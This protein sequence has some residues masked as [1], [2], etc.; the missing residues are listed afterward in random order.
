MKGNAGL[1]VALLIVLVSAV[2]ILI[3][4]RFSGFFALTTGENASLALWDITDS[5]GGNLYVY[6]D[7]SPL[8]SRENS[9]TLARFYANYTN[10]TSGQSI[11]GT[12]VVCNISFNV[13]GAFT[14]PANMWFNASSRLYVYNR[15]FA[16]RG[17]YPWNA[18]CYGSS[19]NYDTLTTVD[20]VTVTNTPAGIYVPLLTKTCY[21]DTICYHN[22]SADCYDIDDVDENNLTY[23]YK[24]GTDFSG[25]GINTSTGNITVYVTNDTA[26]GDFYVTLI[27]K[28]S[29]GWGSTA[30]KEFVV[31]AVNDAPSL[32]SVQ[33]SSYQNSSLYYDIDATD[34]E[35]PSGPFFFNITFLACYRPFSSQHTNVSNCTG[36]FAI[37]SSTGVINRTVVFANSEVG[38]YT[39]NFTVTDTGNNLSGT[40]T[41]PYA[42]LFN[43]TDAHVINFTVIDINDR[44]AISAVANQFWSQGQSVTLVINASDIDN[45]TLAFSAT[46]LYRN[47]SSYYN[48]SLFPVAFNETLRLD[49]GT[50]LGNAT[51]NFAPLLNGQVGNY[52]LNF[53]VYDGRQNGTQSLLVNFTI[54][55]I[56]DQPSLNFSCR[57]YSV[58]GVGYYCNVGQNTTDPDNFASYVPYTD[59]VNGTLTYSINFTYCNKTFNA[60]DTNCSIFAINQTTG[61]INYTTPLRNDTG[62]Y[63]LN[64]TVTDGGNLAASSVFN[65]TVIADYAPNITTSI[66]SQT[67]T[68]DQAFFLSVNATDLDNAT[69]T[70]AFR[71]ETYYR[72][73][74]LLNATKF[75]IQTDLGYWPLGPA[76]G[77]M[78]YTTINNSQ[79]GNYTVKIIVNDTWG[80]EDYRLVNFTVYN[81]NDPPVINFTCL[82]ATNETTYYSPTSYLCNVG[83]NTTDPDQQTPYGD[84]LTYGMAFLAGLP[85]FSINPATG[86]IN[87]SAAN[88]SWANSS[89]NFTYAVNITVSDSSGLGA[90]QTLNITVYAVN[91]PPELN[92]TNTSISVNSTYFENVSAEMRDEEN[93]APFAFNV[94]F[95]N[96]SKTNTSDTNCSIFAINQTTGVI[97]F[98]ALEKDRGNYTLNVTVR[99]SGNTTYPHNA[100]GWKL[101]SFRL[102]AM[103]HAPG[104]DIVGT[105]N[106][107][108]TYTSS[109]SENDTITFM[110]NVSDADGDTLSCTW[111][112]NS[113]QIGS[114]E[115]CQDD[116]T[117]EYTPGFDEAGYWTMRLQVSDSQST[118]YD[119]WNVN[120]SNRNRPPELIYPAQNQSWNM[121]TVNRN[122]VL[123]YN[124][125]DPDNENSVSNDD[126]NLTINYTGPQHVT[127]M[128]D[129]HLPPL[130][131]EPANWT[132]KAAVT[133][134]PQ[135]DWYGIESIIF[136]VNDS[137]ASASSNNITL[138]V[139]YT[140]ATQQTVV[141]QSGGGGGG[142]TSSGTK[143]ASLTITV[144]PMEK[145]KAF[146]RTSAVVTL[147]NTGQVVLSNISIRVYVKEA[148]DIAPSLTKSS[149]GQLTTN[150]EA[151]TTLNIV[152]YELTKDNY[153]VK[154]TAS[155]ADPKFN[156]STT[157]YIRPIFNET[158]LEERIQ[159]ARDLFQDNPECIDLME[160]IFQA[161]KEVTG[162]N[163][164][165]AKQLTESAIENC[166]DIIQYANAT[167]RKVTP[168]AET[169]P[170]NEITIALLFIS[171]VAVVAYNMAEKRA[172][173]RKEKK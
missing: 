1:L 108:W 77:M 40:S 129:D 172:Q 14:S 68:Q 49:N 39:V 161:E 120:I 140:E 142:A 28:D 98:S 9:T 37:N 25:F 138:N 47:L 93:D 168:E 162:N 71:T 44:P 24:A 88:D 134:T 52:T 85:L 23:G 99:D 153:E 16:S 144:S 152:T 163:V 26:C 36:L 57:N 69:D 78:N 35:T 114:V 133:L 63:T 19:Q 90:S 2:F 145:I 160:L 113:T 70:L 81:A 166:R 122:I 125:R 124:F 110:I 159:V 30:D 137:Q 167:K 7:G 86:L 32:G 149:V 131:I 27:D 84:T 65:F 72:N 66:A 155:V 107:N 173:A 157:I 56:N 61:V 55:N 132:N 170:I 146:N 147:K 21:E 54:Y 45:G 48:T 112:R 94:T 91:D 89:L 106:I 118:A 148:N 103:N 74:T 11:N 20:N 164:E 46:T 141:Q 41:P 50:S 97:N 111:F 119:E 127:V 80:R 139:S 12:G 104:A 121:N 151:N 31:N 171:L 6:A 100:T 4:L 42:W 79:V 8:G 116:S 38:N 96:C 135:T 101:V 102:T 126:N 15:S 64:V 130:S 62:N 3:P 95:V 17:L 83:Q 18:T 10:I 169:I 58:E 34:E 43:E 51:L 67:A 154:L 82:N 156:Q 128:I 105:F 92:F 158:R 143:V 87:F 136:T 13:S 75:P 33:S 76:T 60:S 53:S 59:A 73:G 117:W 115:S 109:F 29:T 165:K 150:E 5:Q 123:S 22:F